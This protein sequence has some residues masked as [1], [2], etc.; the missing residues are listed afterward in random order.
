VRELVV[1]Q[2]FKGVV[3]QLGAATLP[4]QLH[5]RLNVTCASP[6]RD[7]GTKIKQKAGWRVWCWQPTPGGNYL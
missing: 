6:W 4:Q 2:H 1:R 5:N 7:A 3:E